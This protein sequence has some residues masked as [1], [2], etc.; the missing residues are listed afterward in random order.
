MS[1]FQKALTTV[2]ELTRESPTYT[3]F[4]QKAHGGSNH[5]PNVF[6]LC[7]WFLCLLPLPTEAP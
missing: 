7:G 5:F 1:F 2:A 3:Q 4:F 6:L